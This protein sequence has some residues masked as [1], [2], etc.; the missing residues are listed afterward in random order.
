MLAARN[1]PLDDARL[2]WIFGFFPALKKFWL[3][4]AGT[5]SGGQKQMLSI[6]RAIVE[7]RKLI[8]IDEPTKGLAPAI[9]GA[10]IEC[11]DEIKRARRHH[12]AGRAEFP[13]RAG[14]RRPRRVMDST[15]ASS[16]P[17]RW[18]SSPPT[19]ACSSVFS[20]S[21][22]T[23]IN[24]AIESRRPPGAAPPQ[25]KTGFLPSCCRWCWRRCY[26]VRRLVL[27]LGDADAR[28]SRHGHDDLRHGVGADAGV[29]PD[30]RAEFRPRRLHLRRRLSGD[31]RARAAGGLVAGRFA[32]RQSRR[33]GARRCCS[34]WRCR[35]RSGYVFER[36]LVASG[37]RPA[38]QA[39]P[40]HHGRADRR[41]TGALRVC[42]ARSII[43]LP[44]PG[45]AAR[46]LR[47]FGD[48]AIDKYRVLAVVVGLVVF[49]ATATRAQPHQDRA[50]DP[51]R[52]REQA[53]WSRR[54]ATASAGCS[55]ACSWPARRSPAS[56]A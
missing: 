1:G 14:S 46:L 56:A 19:T 34:P 55:S 18:P 36:V 25:Q 13:R 26:A 27:D 53:R 44:L 17:A 48:I 42:R 38:S 39:D 49:V 5:L 16:M 23:A 51:R 4:R 7:Q 28:R 54:S 41:R 31:A 32:R 29:R 33:A 8:L 24:D 37:L 6:A 12:P 50:A 9:V 2:D 20:A 30:G 47:F 3:S 45:G 43:P 22:W 21:A 40:D 11:L 52:R 35:A 15:A 10:L